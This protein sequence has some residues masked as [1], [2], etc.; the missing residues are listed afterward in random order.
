MPKRPQAN[1][2]ILNLYIYIDLKYLYIDKREKSYVNT[3]ASSYLKIFGQV[4]I[5]D[6]ADS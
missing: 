4:H 2:N 3:T 6:Q 1:L 5:H